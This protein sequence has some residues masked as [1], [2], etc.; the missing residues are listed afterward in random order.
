MCYYRYRCVVIVIVKAADTDSSGTTGAGGVV[1]RYQMPCE[2]V[3]QFM[4]VFVLG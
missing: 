4:I 3:E 1:C 2:L